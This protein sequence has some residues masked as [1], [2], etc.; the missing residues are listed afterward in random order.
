MRTAHSRWMRR[1]VGVVAA[2]ERQFGA[3]D[4]AEDVPAEHDPAAVH[5]VEPAEFVLRIREPAVGDGAQHEQ[6]PEL[7]LVIAGT[8]PLITGRTAL[9]CSI[10]AARSPMFMLSCAS[11]VRGVTAVHGPSSSRASA[12]ARWAASIAPAVSPVF[13]RRWQSH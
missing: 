6:R 12:S 11:M 7:D 2:G 10:A 3:A 13:S 9:A 4:L 5:P 1:P 8:E